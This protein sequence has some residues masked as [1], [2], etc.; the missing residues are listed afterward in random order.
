MS[1]PAPATA[2]ARPVW[3]AP[4]N[5]TSPHILRRSALKQQQPKP[6]GTVEA[7]RLLSD[8]STADSGAASPELRGAAKAKH[9]AVDQA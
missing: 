5:L 6:T 8:E 4:V 1:A 3:H 2:H 9:V 7:A